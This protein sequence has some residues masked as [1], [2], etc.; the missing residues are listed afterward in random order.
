MSDYDVTVGTTEYDIELSYGGAKGK[1]GP[2]GLSGTAGVGATGST[3]PTGPTGIAGSTGSKGITGPTGAGTMGATGP[4][5]SVGP[6]GSVGSTGPTGSGT[7]GATGIAG[8]TG[9]T[10][11][12]G[13]TGAT[14]PT[15]TD[16]VY[17]GT[18]ERDV[19]GIVDG[20]TFTSATMTEMWDTLIKEE[21]FPSLT[22]PSSTF[23]STIT[24]YREVD[25][26]IDITFNSAFNRGGISPQ[27]TAASPYRSG[28]PNTYQ[29]TGTDLSNQSKTDLTDAQVVSS[30]SVVINGQSWQGKVAYDAGVQPKSSY[31]NDYST[32]LSAGTTSYITRTIT[33]VYPYYAT[34]SAIGT[35]TKQT[36]TSMSSSYVQTDVV[37]EDGVDVQTAD[38]P[39]AWSA[40]T[41][42]QFYNTVSTAWEWINGSA[43]NSLLTFTQSA[44][45]HTIQ[46]NVVNYT[47]YAHTGSLLGARK[48]RWYTT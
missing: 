47:K 22:N 19:G 35:L 33:G 23:T 15:G 36:L 14:G 38:F 10:G 20:A 2:T 18:A 25:D 24:G 34:T 9:P 26:T 41:G 45:T 46:G 7:T 1:T 43:A 4:T 31:G 30:Y 32:P 17:S 40:I 6:S 28:L 12:T 44:T 27:Y 37:A 42:I 13:I 16:S 39:I 11:V 5:G 8:I 48:L 21:K 3:G 29:F